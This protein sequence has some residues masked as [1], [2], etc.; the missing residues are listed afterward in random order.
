MDLFYKTY[1]EEGP[2]LVILHGLLGASGNWHTLS[3]TRFAEVAR[4]VTVDQRNH[5][6]SPHAD[7]FDYDALAGDIRAFID[8]HGLRPAHVLGHSMGGKTAMQLALTAPEAVDRLVVV[9]MA[10]KAYPPHHTDLLEALRGIDPT[11]YDSR[12]AIDDALAE[13]VPSTP[14]R[15]FLLKNLHYDGQTYTW[16]MN[17]E[18]IIDHYDR[19]NEAVTADEPYDGPALFVR[20]ERSDYV[21]D[22]DREP[23]RRLFPNAEFA[24][25]GGA[26][27]WVHADAPE[28]FADVVVDFLTTEDVL[29]A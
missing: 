23:I 5:G 10:P 27:H 4:P 25:V 18:A 19:I 7:R 17:L 12:S 16:Q 28:A 14:V 8:E 1:G 3:R 2:P 11:A 6:R 26:G 15:Q 29:A 24:T 20:G 22:E 9:D 21:A 13:D